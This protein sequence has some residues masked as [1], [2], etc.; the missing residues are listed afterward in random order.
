VVFDLKILNL[1]E[2]GDSA[3]L[4]LAHCAPAL[5][6][7]C[8]CFGLMKCSVEHLSAKLLQAEQFVAEPRQPGHQNF[9]PAQQGLL[10]DSLIDF[11]LDGVDA[12]A[13][14]L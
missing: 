8:Y 9:G 7:G 11:D 10:D 13:G 3:D 4:L 14:E 5:F 1:L 6:E 12:S 2:C